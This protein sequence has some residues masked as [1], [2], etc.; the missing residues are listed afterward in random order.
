[1]LKMQETFARMGMLVVLAALLAGC[2]DDDSSGTSSASLASGASSARQGTISRTPNPVSSHSVA[3]N[4]PGGAS[5][6]SSHNA[7]LSWEA[8]TTNTNGSAL[9]D[10]SG[11]RIYYG[12]S[13]GELSES[14]QITN[15]GIQTYVI[16][17]L[18]PGTW[19]FAIRA[20]TSA[21]TESALSNIVEMTIG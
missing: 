9:T 11:Y 2:G 19:Y 15:V 7:M 13:A 5:P 17:N 16:E 20:T 6:P 4:P 21:G 3:S 14:V 10:L 18:Q 8:P 1:V 12:P